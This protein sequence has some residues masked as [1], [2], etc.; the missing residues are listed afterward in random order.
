MK[1]NPENTEP[2][3]ESKLNQDASGS[4]QNYNAEDPTKI[5]I[6]KDPTVII[7]G[8][9]GFI[10]STLSLKSDQHDIP[11]IIKTVRD[12]ITFKGY[13]VW[14]LIC[15]IIVASVGLNMNS[16]A[17]IVGA[18]LISPLMGPIRGIGVGVG[19]NDLRMLKESIKNYGVMVGISFLVAFLY[20][21]ATPIKGITSELGGRVE[22]SFL[23]VVI[24]FF[25]GLAGVIAL[26]KGKN[27][28]VIPG[29]AIATALMPPLCTAGYGLA[30][31]N[32][33]Y[34]LG[35]SYLF[36]LNSLLIALSTIIL[37]RYLKFPKMEYLTPK[38]EKRVQ[39]YIIVFMIVIVAPSGWLFYKMTMRSVFESNAQA[40]VEEVVMSYDDKMSVIPTYTYDS[41]EYENPVIE[42]NIQYSHIDTITKK[43]WNKQKNAYGLDDALIVVNQGEDFDAILK[44]WEIG[45]ENSNTGNNKLI[46]NINRKDSEIS[47]LRKII[48]EYRDNPVAQ[49]DPLDINHLLRG[50]KIDYPELNQVNV[51]RGFALNSAGELDTTYVLSVQ[52]KPSIEL[53]DRIKIKSKISRRLL[54]E[55]NEKTT[56]Q[57]DSVQVISY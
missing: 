54:L 43:A 16:T 30:I 38:I 17:V 41:D 26:V 4:S 13:N 40:F 56:S 8:T 29:V 15:S 20:F 47:R 27:D 57:Q 46:D 7:S 10:R 3:E 36:L 24:A 52:F 33:T 45:W 28:T 37:I 25:G 39:G 14:I 34:F 22:P 19:T 9:W 2:T 44:E 31:G 49:K 1:E 12:G 48:D 32:W 11:A 35:A 55:I 5:H 6:E 18:M 42:L 50:F 53:E 21:L 23:D 51:N